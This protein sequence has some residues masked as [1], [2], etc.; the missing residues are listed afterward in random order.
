MALG[1]RGL[2]EIV[3]AVR[4]PVLAIGGTTIERM[5][6]IAAAGAA[7]FAAISLFLASQSMA[8]MVADARAR[9]DITRATS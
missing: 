9:F 3:Q 8:D 4:T 7:G 1:V 2:R 6:Q 5:P